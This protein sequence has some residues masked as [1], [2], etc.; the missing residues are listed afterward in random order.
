MIVALPLEFRWGDLSVHAGAEELGGWPLVACGVQTY[1][2]KMEVIWHEN[3]KRADQA[4][5][6]ECV[7]EGLSK[8]RMKAVI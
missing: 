2:D 4:L 6:T 1:P 3:V 5:P 8:A 7:E